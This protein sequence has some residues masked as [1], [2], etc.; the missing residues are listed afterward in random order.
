MDNNDKNRSVF[1]RAM[2]AAAVAAAMAAGITA[3]AQFHQSISVEGKYVPDIIRAD[4][5]NTFPKALRQSLLSQPL[6]YEQGGVAASFSPSLLAMPATG[7]RASRTVNSNPGYLELGAGS[8][9]NTDL[10][11]GYR[12]IDNSSTLFGA[13]LQFNST[14]MWKPK[15]SKQTQDVKQELYDGSFALYASHVVK[16]YGRL[17]AALDYQAAYF[18]YY[19]ISGDTGIQRSPV[20]SEIP[21]AAPTQTLNDIALR[22]D[23][24]PLV[25]PDNSVTYHASARVRHFG[26]RAMPIPYPM[27]DDGLKGGRETGLTLAGGVRMPWDGGSSIGLDAGF[28]LMF[29][30]GDKRVTVD[31]PGSDSEQ[32][33]LPALDDYGLLTLT[34]YYRFNRGLLD[35]R[36]GADLD[37]AFNA[38]PDG[39]RYPFLHVAPDVRVALQTGQVGLWLN[40]TG[41]SELNTLSR[42]RQLDYYGMPALTT[43]RPTH[44][45]LDATLGVNLGPFSGF[46]IGIEGSFKSMKN[47]PLGGWY[48]A[49]LNVGDRAMAGLVPAVPSEAETLYSLDTEGIDLHG[50]SLAGHMEYR[51]G[52]LFEISAR[53]SVQPQDGKK[54]YFNG[55]DRPK[56][57]ALFKAAVSPVKQLRIAASYDFRGKRH[58]YTRSQTAPSAGT[59]EIDGRSTSLHSLHLPDLTLLGLSATWNLNPSAAIWIQADNLLNRHD[60]ALPSQPMQGV[61]VTGGFSC[62][63]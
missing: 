46:S 22:L 51:H 15:Q 20:L 54:G 56:I 27:P 25:S 39:H 41:G 7:W 53:G 48:Q 9:L 21:M 29:E 5:I 35:V 19:G 55:Y 14:S 52:D 12:F 58:I 8:W 23:W 45:P 33:R 31:G 47:V 6:E 50:F 13:R 26:Y 28:D 17:D 49:W 34:P 42:L 57:T 4:R 2:R 40:A 44:T 18:N 63:F 62:T 16:G 36:L 24:R 60:E 30:G 11:A 61:V 3:S 43:T 38:G 59:V 32:F 1:P 37:L 10:S